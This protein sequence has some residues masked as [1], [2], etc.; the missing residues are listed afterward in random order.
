VPAPTPT[1]T[2]QPTLSGSE[3]PTPTA[4]PTF[5]A[6]SALSPSNRAFFDKDDLI[7]LRWVATGALGVGQSYLIHVEDQTNGKA[8]AATTQD[9][10]FIIP[11]NWHGQENTRHDYVWTISVVDANNPDT[12]YYT[13]EARIFTW[14]GQGS[15]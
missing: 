14:Q 13:T 12:S 15:Q 2:I 5:N 7:T 3:T 11:E 6:P 1:P 10:F 8:Y 9:L 4:T